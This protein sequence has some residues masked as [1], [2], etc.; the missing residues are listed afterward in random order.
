[1]EDGC[2][3]R[4]DLGTMDLRAENASGIGAAKRQF[5]K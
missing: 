4:F 1:M 5:G 2:S 3:K